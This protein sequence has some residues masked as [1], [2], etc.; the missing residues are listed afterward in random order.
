MS[1]AFLTNLQ[2]NP[3]FPG[4]ATR[5]KTCTK[6]HSIADNVSLTGQ[7]NP[8]H[9]KA[10]TEP[11]RGYTKE[12]LIFRNNDTLLGCFEEPH[13]ENNP[14][15]TNMQLII[16]IYPK[17]LT[18]AYCFAALLLCQLMPALKYKPSSSRPIIIRGNQTD[19]VSLFFR[20]FQSLN[21]DSK[22]LSNRSFYQSGFF[23]KAEP[24]A[25]LTAIPD[26]PF[27]TYLLDQLKDFLTTHEF[28]QEN[29]FNF[30]RQMV[31]S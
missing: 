24:Q 15:K 18:F 11:L 3:L 2:N 27:L 20:I 16:T 25:S 1:K 28:T 13:A 10:N 17:D 26:D 22:S 29:A 8:D 4:Y 23:S 5:I 7:V 9:Y 31:F 14:Y 12:H 30:N 19:V 6:R 21:L